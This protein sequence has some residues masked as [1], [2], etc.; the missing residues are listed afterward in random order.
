MSDIARLAGVSTTTVSHVVNKTRPVAEETEAAVLAAIARTGYVADSVVRSQRTMGTQTIGLAM[1]AIT[2][3]Y[4]GEV[5][6]GLE[7][8]ASAKGY[9]LLLADTHDEAN[10]ELR[11]VSDLLSRRVEAIVLAPSTDAAAAARHAQLQGVPVVIIDRLVDAEVDQIGSENVESTAQLVDHL[12]GNGHRRIGMIS[13]RPGLSTTDERVAGYRLGLRRNRI[14]V[15]SELVVSGDSGDE[16]AADALRALMS[17]SRPPTAVVVGNNLMTIGAMRG[18]RELGITVPDDLALTSFDDFEWADLF[19][20]RLTVI[21][22]ATSQMGAQ[23]FELVMSRLAD[24]MLPSRRIVMRT[25]FVH[26]DSCGCH[27]GRA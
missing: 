2:N 20:P 11:A 23:A 18:A 17:L 22:Q 8:A 6:H 10:A 1:S 3:P 4:F 24:P 5:V 25:K 12:A 9:S 16:E 7:R 27:L 14:R 26:R 19:H 21:A 15:A 13:G